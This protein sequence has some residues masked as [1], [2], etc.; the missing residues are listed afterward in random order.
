MPIAQGEITEIIS[1]N[2]L[3][4]IMQVEVFPEITIDKKY[5]DIKVKKT[6]V[7]LGKDEV[8]NTLLDIQKRF[9]KF[10]EAAADY[11]TKMGDKVTITTQGYDAKGKELPNTDMKSY[12]IVL[13][14]NMLVPGFEEG[15]VG[16]TTGSDVKL[17]VTFPKDYHNTE[18]AGKKTKFDVK[19]EKIEAAVAPE[20]TPEFIKDL[21]GKDLDLKGFKALISEELLETKE[22][23][24]RLEDEN[25]LIDELLP[26]SNVEFGPSL[27]KNQMEKVYAEIKENI[28]SS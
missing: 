10:E 26:L 25:K 15:L 20:F 23:N 14:S 19:I 16:F 12:P 28:S 27:L 24:A 5:K 7:K 9:T 11:V 4:L 22:M 6:S 18:F 8:E 3:K 13:G 1:Q 2:P 21:R 17:D